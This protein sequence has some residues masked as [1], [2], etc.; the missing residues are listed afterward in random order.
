MN[1]GALCRTAEVLGVRELVLPT[2]DVVAD[3]EFR[4]LAVSAQQWQP[5]T[6]CAATQVAEW[7][8]QQQ[9]GGVTVVALTRHP[10]AISLPN[11]AFPNQTALLLGRELTGIPPDLIQQC[12]AVVEIPQLGRVDS[13]NVQTAAA[14]AAYAY[15]CQHRP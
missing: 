3:A 2:L 1:L 12:D 15:L 7:I 6:A 14:I 4:K 13:L 5:L 9:G 8:R 10:K 11:F